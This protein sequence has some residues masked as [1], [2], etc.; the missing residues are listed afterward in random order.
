MTD[1]LQRIKC[2]GPEYMPWLV[3]GAVCLIIQWLH[4]GETLLF[5]RSLIEQGQIW[6]LLTAHFT[7]LNWNHLWLNLAGVFMV[8]IF[9]GRYVSNRYWIISI[10]FISLFCSAGLMLDK[11]LEN[12]VGFSGV[13][14]GLFIIGARY[15]L[16]RYKTS[17]IVLLVL[18]IGKLIWEQ[19]YGSLPG[20]EEITGGRVAV[21]AHLYG[22]LGGVVYL[23]LGK[24]SGLNKS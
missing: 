12:Y 3:L 1:I 11:Q 20:S 15:E 18:I 14:H 13:L 5:N 21:N 4:L 19:V 23:W 6:R 7:H 2:R 8:A 17:G 16:T 10:I 24:V 22:A 9:F